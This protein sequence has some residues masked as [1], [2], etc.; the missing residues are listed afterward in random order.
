MAI[1]CVLE[2]NHQAGLMSP[3][4]TPSGPGSRTPMVTNG[5]YWKG[6]RHSTRPG[7]LA[8][9]AHSVIHSNPRAVTKQLPLHR[10]QS[11]PVCPPIP[12]PGQ[13]DIM[14]R[15]VLAAA[16]GRPGETA[17]GQLFRAA[18]MT[19]QVSQK[20]VPRVPLVQS[21]PAVDSAST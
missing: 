9:A 19:P 5:R 18:N 7:C 20:S 6:H 12:P 21:T 2:A 13:E 15:E 1:Q 17:R 14:R 10:L 3:F 16:A 4:G 8:G 11:G